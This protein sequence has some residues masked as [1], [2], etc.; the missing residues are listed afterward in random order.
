[1]GSSKFFEKSKF[2]LLPI[3]G[4]KE[5]VKSPYGSYRHFKKTMK[6]KYKEYLKKEELSYLRVVDKIPKEEI[7]VLK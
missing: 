4:K 5:M 3:K 1:M 7:L 6:D 2:L